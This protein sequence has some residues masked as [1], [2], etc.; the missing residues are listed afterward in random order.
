VLFGAP[1]DRPRLLAIPIGGGEVTAVA[2]LPGK[3]AYGADGPDGPELLLVHDGAFE[4]WHLTR[5]GRIEPRG[6]AAFVVPA[7]SGGWRAVQTYDSPNHLRFVAPGDPLTAGMHE[8]APESDRPM[9]LDDHRI[10]YA[11][12][13]AFH[14]VDVTTGAEVATLPGPEWGQKAV[15]ASDGVHW[16]DVQLIGHVTR[17][18]I[19]NFADR[20]W[21]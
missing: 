4:A 5:D 16:Y 15:L 19:V 3:L 18:L 14:V 8:V 21:R 12:R 9:W 2:D 17:H 1:G 7:P 13:G 20:P 6:M 11:A 10:A